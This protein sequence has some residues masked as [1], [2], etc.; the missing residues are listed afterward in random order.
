MNLHMRLWCV[1][2][3]LISWTEL[4]ENDEGKKSS[5]T[6]W[7]IIG[8]PVGQVLLYQPGWW[9][10]ALLGA[11]LCLWFTCCWKVLGFLKCFTQPW[12]TIIVQGIC[13]ADKAALQTLLSLHVSKSSPHSEESLPCS[14]VF[15]KLNQSSYYALPFLMFGF[16][17]F[18]SSF[19][20]IN[21]IFIFTFSFPS[22]ADLILTLSQR[23]KCHELAVFVLSGLALINR[24]WV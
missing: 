12:K 7:L 2:F 15:R 22:S 8:S 16:A 24:C 4:L 1:R 10:R 13:S 23:R 19:H 17:R 20:L 14:C 11:S 9:G 3:C 5:I 21:C 6:G 18:K